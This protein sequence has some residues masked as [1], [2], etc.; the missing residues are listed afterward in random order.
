MATAIK[1]GDAYGLPMALT[2]DGTALNLSDVD[3]VEVCIGEGVRKLY[4]G[5]ITYSPEDGYFYIPLTQAE[6]FSM[7]AD[8]TVQIDVRVKFRGG[9]V[10][11]CQQ[12]VQASVVDAVSVQE[13]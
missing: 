3:T 9:N 12:M 6:T 8:S 1:Q 5:E 10:I 7:E 4:P 2:L 11:G 13:L